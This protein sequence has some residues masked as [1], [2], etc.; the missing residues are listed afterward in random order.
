ML[1][2]RWKV[3]HLILLNDNSLF[4]SGIGYI[5]IHVSRDYTAH[6]K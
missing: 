4:N 1:Y 6:L 3:F 2:L 5:I